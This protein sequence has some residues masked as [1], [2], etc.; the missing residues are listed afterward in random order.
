MWEVLPSI[1]QGVSLYFL[2]LKIVNTW[3][4]GSIT[5]WLSASCI[6]FPI[7]SMKRGPSLLLSYLKRFDFNQGSS[8]IS[9]WRHSKPL[10]AHCVGNSHPSQQ[11]HRITFFFSLQLSCMILGA[12]ATEAPNVTIKKKNLISKFITS[13]INSPEEKLENMSENVPSK[14]WTI[15]WN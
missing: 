4:C 11:R 1:F 13:V 3:Y 10:T 2:R 15:E 5:W 7:Y 9:Y 12:E 8:R 6:Y 14:L